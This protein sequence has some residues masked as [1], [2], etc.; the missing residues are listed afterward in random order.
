MSLF[1][2]LQHI[3]K[4]EFFDNTGNK[5]FEDTF[6]NVSFYQPEINRTSNNSFVVQGRINT[7]ISL[8]NAKTWKHVIDMK[9]SSIIDDFDNDISTVMLSENIINAPNFVMLVE[10]QNPNSPLKTG[11]SLWSNTPGAYVIEFAD[12]EISD[13]QST[14]SN[15]STGSGTSGSNSSPDLAGGETPITQPDAPQKTPNGILSWLQNFRSIR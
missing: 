5:F 6:D 10:A 3:K 2:A 9:D 11:I 12:G 8:D 15:S 4:I 1:P 7:Y 13:T 14:S